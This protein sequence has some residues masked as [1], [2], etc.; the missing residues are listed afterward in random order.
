M[1]SHSRVDHPDWVCD[2][3]GGAP[4]DSSGDHRL[5]SR[6][7]LGRAGGTDCCSFEEG[8]GPLIP[9]AKTLLAGKTDAG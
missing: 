8:T 3:N 2:E 6:E 9:W 1:S 5:D 4:R 7:L